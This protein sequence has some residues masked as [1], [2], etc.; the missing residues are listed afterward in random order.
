[1]LEEFYYLKL[2]DK[3]KLLIDNGFRMEF[4]LSPSRSTRQRFNNQAAFNVKIW[5]LV[6]NNSTSAAQIASWAMKDSG[7]ATLVCDVT[8]GVFGGTRQFITLPN[9]G[10]QFEMDLLYVVDSTGRPL[11]AGTIPHHFNRPGMD[12]LATTLAIIAEGGY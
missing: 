12:A 6:G 9:S 5:L 1:M 10:V 3:D 2:T 8:G 7:L 11:E 4:S